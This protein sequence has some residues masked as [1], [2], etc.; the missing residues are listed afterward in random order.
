MSPIKNRRQLL[1]AQSLSKRWDKILKDT[2]DFI[3]KDLKIISYTSHPE[4][5][6]K[7]WIKTAKIKN[8]RPKIRNDEQIRTLRKQGLTIREIAK[9]SNHSTMQVQRALK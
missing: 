7:E 1:K 6:F 5:V 2:F 3:E 9:Q 4:R 8:G